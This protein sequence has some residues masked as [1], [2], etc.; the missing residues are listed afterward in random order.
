[1]PDSE[2]IPKEEIILTGIAASPGVADGTAL[3]YLQHE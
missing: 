3:L 2:E 1:M